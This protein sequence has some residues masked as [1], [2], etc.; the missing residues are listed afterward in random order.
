MSIRHI[1]LKDCPKEK[2]L[3]GESQIKEVPPESNNVDCN[4]VLKLPN[5][6]I[7]FEKIRN[8]C[9]AHVASKNGEYA[10]KIEDIL[11]LKKLI[12]LSY[13]K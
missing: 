3:F 9:T 10:K 4:C 8:Y 6:T 2:N 12:Y 11:R 7:V 1:I 13:G 5:A